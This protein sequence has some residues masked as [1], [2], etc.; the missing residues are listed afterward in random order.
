MSTKP[1]PFAARVRLPFVLV[2]LSVLPFKSR[3]STLRLSILLLESTT[4]AEEAVRNGISPEQLKAILEI[5]RKAKE[6]K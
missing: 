5:Y 2:T 4:I 1:V 6:E 3:L